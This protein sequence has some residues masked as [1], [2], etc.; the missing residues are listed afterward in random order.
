MYGGR[1]KIVVLWKIFRIHLRQTY[2]TFLY[3]RLLYNFYFI[4]RRR[5]SIIF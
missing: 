5:F 2:K 1:T 4:F 3:I